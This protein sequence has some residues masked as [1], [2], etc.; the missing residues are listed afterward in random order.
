M[1][2]LIDGDTFGLFRLETVGALCESQ[3]GCVVDHVHLGLENLDREVTHACT[4]CRVEQ[5]VKRVFNDGSD[6]AMHIDNP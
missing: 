1:R 4:V 5:K 6:F 3:R 2:D